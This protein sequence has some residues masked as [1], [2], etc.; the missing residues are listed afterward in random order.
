MYNIYIIYMYTFPF[1][2][3]FLISSLSNI[4]S[5]EIGR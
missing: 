3:M 1:V 2:S 5:K 4:S